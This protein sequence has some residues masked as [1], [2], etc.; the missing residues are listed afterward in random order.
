MLVSADR[1]RTTNIDAHKVARGS[2]FTTDAVWLNQRVRE[3]LAFALLEQSVS[4]Q[5]LVLDPFAGD[6]HMLDLVATEFGVPV[7]GLDIANERWPKND[8]LKRIPNKGRAVILTNPPYLANHSASRKGVSSI[9]AS[10]F[11]NNA[12]ANLYRIALDRCL[13]SADFVIAIIPETFLLSS[14][15]K[16]RLALVSVIE[17]N[18]FEDTDAPAVVACFGPAHSVGAASVFVADRQIGNLPD[19]LALRGASGRIGKPVVFNIPDG[20]I[21]LRAV[22][23]ANGRNP[24]EFMLAEDFKYPPERIKVSS[25]LMTYLDVPGVS[26]ADLVAFI[27][28]ANAELNRIREASEDLVLAPFKG[29]TKLGRRRRRLD[30]ELAREILFNA[31]A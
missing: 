13:E 15:P 27:G 6:G 25:R 30:Y 22:D 29:N 17:G 5:P 10:Y 4:G 31:I 21:G 12:Q 2:F 16:E 23:S 11:K 26:D 14:Y 8:S 24:I 9:V 3:F 28:R 18:L 1:G 20:R 19:I 7:A